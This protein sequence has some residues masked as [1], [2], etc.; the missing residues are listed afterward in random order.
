M[1]FVVGGTWMETVCGES[2][3]GYNLGKWST[4]LANGTVEEVAK[5]CAFRR[6]SGR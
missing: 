1:K 3:N 4:S 6:K 5:N 2:T